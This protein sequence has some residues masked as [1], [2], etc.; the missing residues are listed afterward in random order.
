VQG[1]GAGVAALGGSVFG[2][3]AGGRRGRR[4]GGRG[5][6]T[7]EGDSVEEVLDE[8]REGVEVS[9]FDGFP[10][11]GEGSEVWDDSAS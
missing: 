8:G 10:L 6:D 4:G 1:P 9:G 7:V 5:W 2:V 11:M 3:G